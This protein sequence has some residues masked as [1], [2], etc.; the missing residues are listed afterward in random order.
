MKI[1]YA[2]I[3]KE[4]PIDKK[5]N[6]LRHELTFRIN[7][8]VRAIAFRLS[9]IQPSNNIN[10]ILLR[11]LNGESNKRINEMQYVNK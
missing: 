6:F 4:T 10:F 11:W 1:S 3:G 5:N 2:S 9:F 7:N 8:K